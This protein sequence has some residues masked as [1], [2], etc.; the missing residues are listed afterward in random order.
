[1]WHHTV[2]LTKALL[3][4]QMAVAEVEKNIKNQAKQNNGREKIF[5]KLPAVL[6]VKHE[7]V[8]QFE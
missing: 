6:L 3:H 2:I 1:M 8:A 7:N 5:V 4:G